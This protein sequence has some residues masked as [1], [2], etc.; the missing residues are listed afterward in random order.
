MSNVKVLNYLFLPYIQRF[1][2]IDTY[3]SLEVN[4]FQ[5]N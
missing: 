3:I 4:N 5:Q 2:I 1:Q